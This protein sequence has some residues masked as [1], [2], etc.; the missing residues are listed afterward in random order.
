MFGASIAAE[1]THF[2]FKCHLINYLCL[3]REDS[4]MSVFILFVRF[5]VLSYVTWDRVDVFPQL[6]VISTR[7]IIAAWNLTC[8]HTSSHSVFQN[9]SVPLRSLFNTLESHSHTCLPY[10]CL[11]RELVANT[12]HKTSRLLSHPELWNLSYFI[13]SC[14]RFTDIALETA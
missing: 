6:V 1:M 3:L 7:V 9:G 11:G 4:L 5:V 13:L 8:K 14:T 2:L 12:F 10:V